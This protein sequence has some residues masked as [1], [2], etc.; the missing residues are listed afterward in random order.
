M[1]IKWCSEIFKK[2]RRCTGCRVFYE[3]NYFKKCYGIFYLFWL[4]KLKINLFLFPLKNFIKKRNI[5]K[6]IFYDDDIP[7]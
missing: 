7:F 2:Q 6:S 1:K 4:I 3:H 5:R